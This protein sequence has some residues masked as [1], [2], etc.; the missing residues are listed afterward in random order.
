MKRKPFLFKKILLPI[1][2]FFSGTTIHSQCLINQ[3]FGT[4][5]PTS[6]L[7]G[8]CGGSVDV[9]NNGG[10]YWG[11]N[12][13]SMD[14]NAYLGMHP[15]LFGSSTI[16]FEYVSFPLST[17]MVPGTTYT[18][19][20]YQAIG[21]LHAL[22]GLAFWAS[23]NLGNVPGYFNVYAGN[24]LC[25]TTELIYSSTIIPDESAGWVLESFSYTATSAYN[26]IT[27]IPLG[28][29]PGDSTPYML[30]DDLMFCESTVLPVTF[31]SL[32]TEW[33]NENKSIASI[34][35]ETVSEINNDF[36]TI[37]RSIDGKNWIEAG[38]VNGSGNSN[39]QKNYFFSDQ[40]TNTIS[41]N[42]FYYRIKQTD[43]DGKF[44]Y[45]NISV[46]QRNIFSV[47]GPN[48]NPVFQEMN[49]TVYSEIKTEVKIIIINYL[50]QTIKSEIF[51]LEKGNQPVKL[52]MNDIP[53][54]VHL[55]KFEFSETNEIKSVPIMVTRF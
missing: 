21:M 47:S 11:V 4:Y 13:F 54:G 27:V 26:Y 15:E 24:S 51:S 53:N 16:P 1:F 31:I 3:N 14:G 33:T 7:S 42:I 44:S 37:E 20:F 38:R 50:G 43:M 22:G 39:V 45:S 32:K 18:G 8:S 28:P 17:S 19:S 55:V 10:S 29:P 41:G 49:F 30:F 52:V 9:H 23:E 12:E 34:N 5:L 48:P 6:N 35:W 25:N 2:I 46:L 40:L 36:F